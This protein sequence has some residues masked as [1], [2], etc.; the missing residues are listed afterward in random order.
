MNNIEIIPTVVP[1]ELNDIAPIAERFDAVHVDIVDGIFAHGASWPYVSGDQMAALKAGQLFPKKET[2]AYGV[3]A[4]VRDPG[5]LM[6][7]AIRAGAR[8]VT[9]HVEALDAS[10]QD[11]FRTWRE[12]GAN[13]IVIAILFGTSAERL[14]PFIDMCDVLHVMTIKEIGRQGIPFAAESI[15][16]VAMLHEKYPKTII[17][18][19]GGVNET[20]IAGLASAG[21]RRFYV[22][23]AIS[24]AADPV[25]IRSHLE[26]LAQATTES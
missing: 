23:S 16:R 24:Q 10:A 13:E 18:V 5:S 12:I 26:S 17:A 7:H 9:A 19:D 25:S 3:H 2:V 15:G 22:G 21:A 20:N 6:P 4:M 1:K 8:S 11:M 14:E